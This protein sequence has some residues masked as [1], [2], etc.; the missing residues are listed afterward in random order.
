MK[1]LPVGHDRSRKDWMTS[2]IFTKFILKIE[3]NS[4]NSPFDRLILKLLDFPES[5]PNLCHQIQQCYPV[6]GPRFQKK[7]QVTLK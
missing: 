5:E 4:Q 6:Y 2:D 3:R 1:K 7:F